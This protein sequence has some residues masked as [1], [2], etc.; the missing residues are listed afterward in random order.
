M[1]AF[2]N[3][4]IRY[5]FPSSFVGFRMLLSLGTFSFLLLNL[6]GKYLNVVFL[7]NSKT[8]RHYVVRNRLVFELYLYEQNFQLNYS[9]SEITSDDMLS[10]A[11]WFPGA[12]WLSQRAFWSPLGAIWSFCWIVLKIS[13]SGVKFSSASWQFVKFPNSFATFSPGWILQSPQDARLQGMLCQLLQLAE[14]L[15]RL[16]RIRT[17]KHWLWVSKTL[18]KT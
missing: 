13:F 4:S 11:F 18:G 17:I 3:C 10:G 2:R 1:E 14:L 6:L 15:L 7:A 9:N 12:F 8:V 16:H 5:V